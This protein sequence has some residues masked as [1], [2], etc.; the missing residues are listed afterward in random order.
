MS[1]YIAGHYTA[2]WNAIDL[3]TTETGYEIMVHQHEIGVKDDAF[4]EGDADMIQA[5]IDYEI[6]LTSIDWPLIQAALAGQ[7]AIGATNDHVGVLLSTLGKTLVLTPAAGTSAAASGK[8]LTATKAVLNGDYS[9]NK[10][11]QLRKVPVRFRCL[12]DA[13]NSNKAYTLT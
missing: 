10:S 7:N 2:T 13:S 3:G 5:G 4:G 1:T 6:Q 11:H 8:T 12:P 9:W